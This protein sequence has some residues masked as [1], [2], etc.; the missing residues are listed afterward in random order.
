MINVACHIIG[1][2]NFADHGKFLENRFKY[3]TRAKTEIAKSY[4]R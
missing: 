1:L 3:R 4:S 2:L